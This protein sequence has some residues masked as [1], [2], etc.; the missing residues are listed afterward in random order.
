MGVRE[1]PDHST[2]AMGR[3]CFV[4]NDGGRKEIRD[5]LTGKLRYERVF[6]FDRLVDYEDHGI[7]EISERAAIHV[8]DTL[9]WISPKKQHKVSDRLTK[10]EESAKTL[11][12]QVD[13]LLIRNEA[14]C[15]QMTHMLVVNTEDGPLIVD[16][17]EQEAWEEA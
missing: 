13:E 17:D 5:E 15:L 1:I 7:I 14:L 6:T 16:E 12:A 9:G 3:G 2:M 4:L 10:T 11:Q 8:A